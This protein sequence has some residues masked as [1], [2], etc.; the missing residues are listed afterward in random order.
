MMLMIRPR[1]VVLIG[2]ISLAAGWMAGNISS[3]ATQEAA[4]KGRSSGPRPL[5]GGATS[6]APFTAQL[7]KKLEEHPRSPTPGRNP[8]VFGARRA[9]PSMSLSRP[10]RNE[11]EP[12]VRP[13]PAPP[14]LPAF[15]LS[16]IAASEKDGA[17][18]L[19]AILIDNGS[20][21]FVKAGDKLSGGHSVV[22]VDDK[23]I[24]IVDAAG[25]EQLLR[26][27]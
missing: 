4:A 11:T 16:G 17:I 27:P 15:R 2:T 20:M 18:V 12:E 7:R 3:P 8:F 1:T 25:V 23:A 19:T 13:T 24:V 14:P 21:L 22:R 6:V 9:A 5:G 10:E 26:L